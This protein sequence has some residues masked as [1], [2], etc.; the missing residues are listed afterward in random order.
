M[1]VLLR[2]SVQDPAVQL[3]G[4]DAGKHSTSELRS[5]PRHLTFEIVLH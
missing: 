2:A 1:A 3:F 5:Q 4:F